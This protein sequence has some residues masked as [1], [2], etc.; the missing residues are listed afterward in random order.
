MGRRF[1][2]KLGVMPSGREPDS[3]TRSPRILILVPIFNDWGSLSEL[4]P[5]ID[6]VLAGRQIKADVLVVDDGST[7]SS[8]ELIRDGEFCALQRISRLVLRRNLGHQRAIAV[9]LA[10]IED[11]MDHDVV[12]IMD[13]DGEDDPSDVPRLLDRLSEMEFRSIIFA[14]R[15]RRSESLTFCFFYGLYRLLHRILVGERVRVGNFSVVPRQRLESLVVVAELWNHYAASVFR[16]RQP[17][18]TIPTRRAHRLCGRSS[19]NFVSL[20]MHGLAALA[21]FSDVVAVRVLIMALLASLLAIGGMIFA[22]TV[23]FATSWA[24]PGWATTVAGLSVI[25]LAQA[26][27]LATVF[28]FVVLSARQGMAFLPRRDYAMFVGDVITIDVSERNLSS[29]FHEVRT[30]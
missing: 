24:I 9:G 7:V 17:Y 4:L 3:G 6:Q 23:R 1:Q 8:G 19:M 29:T 15:T 21:V 12:V 26:V 20:V 22:I 18:C 2:S 30:I 14:E 28:S 13:G 10:Y 27:S 5:R 16:S 11:R 25:L